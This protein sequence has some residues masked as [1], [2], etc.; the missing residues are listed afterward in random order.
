MIVF[1]DSD[2]VISSLISVSGASHLIL[3]SQGLKLFISNV[4]LEEL[5]R[6]A[7]KLRVSQKQ[8]D[9]LI[10]TRL[11]IVK[12]EETIT[13]IKDKYKEYVYDINDAHIVAGAKASNAGF[14]ISYNI[15]DFKLNKIKS[16]LSI[17]VMTP[18]KILQY[19]RSLQ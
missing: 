14:L 15:K 2:V 17:I 12:L 16:D 9:V 5:Q 11:K 3:Q 4:S 8:L 18:G 6:V 10:N 7:D 19:L 13:E 1:V